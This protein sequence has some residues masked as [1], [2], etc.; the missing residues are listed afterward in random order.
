M[1]ERYTLP[2]IGS[3]WSDQN[4]F[5]VWLKVEILA[6]EAQHELG[7]IPAADLKTIQDKSRFDVQRVLEIEET[8]KHDV[9]AFLTN[10][11][12]YVGPSSRYIHL[13][14]TSSDLLDTALAYQMRQAGLLLAEKLGDFRQVVGKRASQHRD[15]PC[16][17]RTHG[18]HAEP[19]TFGL[20][21][22]MWYDEL[23]RCEQRLQQATERISVG[24]IS[25][26]VGTFAHIDPYVEKYVC[27]KLDLKPAPVSTQ[28]IQ[29][30]RHAE[31]LTVLALIGS[32][33]DKFA[34][35]IRNLQR[36]DL[37][38][39]EE[40]FS[41]GQKGSSAMPHKRNPITCERIAGLARVLRGNA[42]AAM[43][44]V[45]LWHERDITHSSVERVIIP[46]STMTLYYMLHKFINVMAN[47]VVY[48]DN[49]LKNLEATN[50][51]VFS[52]TLLLELVNSGL[53]REQ[54]YAQVQKNAM[55]AWE[56]GD[57][58]RLHIEHD[59]EIIQRIGKEHIAACF[60]LKANLKNVAEIFRRVGLME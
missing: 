50:G 57:D 60:D 5:E 48:P 28:V 36:T 40:F 1:I 26:A 44:N 45:A 34:T 39:V 18:I 17:G 13:G 33:L 12:E 16:I 49:M 37:L 55:A 54:S 25:G 53:T 11:A 31:F 29:R 32:S 10:V 27:E 9:I 20:K 42:L 35:E 59:D 58:F 47:L 38:E 8:V 30:D 46:D 7:N 4:R 52:Q 22:A 43:E 24:K 14:M 51:L 15:T 3:I 2:E 23:A 21:L 56:S 6:C 19:M 41:K